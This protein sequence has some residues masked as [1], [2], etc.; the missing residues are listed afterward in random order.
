MMTFLT[1]DI[2]VTRGWIHFLTSWSCCKIISSLFLISHFKCTGF[3]SIIY[4]RLHLWFPCELFFPP[5]ICYILLIYFPNIWCTGFFQYLFLQ[6]LSLK[7]LTEG[8]RATKRSVDDD[9]HKLF[10]NVMSI[11]PPKVSFLCFIALLRFL[12]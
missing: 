10:S 1:D 7:R 5:Y 6:P 12:Y 4:R 3:Y 9:I 11:H 8:L 2:S